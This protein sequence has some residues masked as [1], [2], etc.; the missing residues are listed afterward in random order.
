MPLPELEREFERSDKVT[1]YFCDF[2]EEEIP[3][4][5]SGDLTGGASISITA[6]EDIHSMES[7]E[8]RSLLCCKRCAS[9]IVA[10]T[11][12]CGVSPLH[13]Q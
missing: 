12:I 6:F 1:K 7:G 9:K 8:R 4:D 11:I 5:G 2:C 3:R 10:R 13:H